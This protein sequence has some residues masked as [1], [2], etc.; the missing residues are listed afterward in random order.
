[1]DLTQGFQA[2]GDTEAPFLN[3]EQGDRLILERFEQQSKANGDVGSYLFWVRHIL[4]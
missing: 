4:P 2:L 3:P 1:M